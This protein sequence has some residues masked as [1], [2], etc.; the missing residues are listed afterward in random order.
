MD[1][2]LN[3]GGKTFKELEQEIYMLGCRMCVNLTKE[4]LKSKDN[5][6]FSTCDKEKYKSEGLRK[7]SIKTVY[8]AVEYKRRVYRTKDEEGRE[9]YVYL[10]DKELGMEKIGLISENL[11]EK[12][13]D[14]ATEAPYRKTA[15]EISSTTGISISAQGAWGL[16]QQIG[17]RIGKEE[18]QAVNQMKTG[19]TEGEKGVPVLLEEMDGI[20]IGQQGP[21]HEKMPKQEVKVAV[22]YEGWDKEKELAGRSTLVGKRVIAGIESSSVFHEKREADIQK[23]YDADEIIQRVVNGDGG[24][25]IGEPNDPDAII[26]LDQFHLYKEIKAKIADKEAQRAIKELLEERKIDEALSYIEIYADSVE[27]DDKT[28][29][30][31]ENARKLLKYM[32]NNKDGL[33]PWT[34][35]GINIPEAPEGIIYKNMGVQENQ[36]CTVISLRMKRGRMRWSGQG[37]NNMA[38]ALYRKENRE[39]HD[40][41]NRYSKDLIFYQEIIEAIAIL[42]A[43]KAPKK[44]GKGNPYIDLVN[45]HLPLLDAKQT[46]PRKAFKLWLN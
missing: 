38:K 1:I 37:G 16:M 31:S 32:T 8:G 19:H 24:S 29:N 11:A 17:E 30:R 35:R 43:A 36:N 34:E 42:S 10:L 15:D 40:T 6:I 3:E 26:Q 18:D 21:N 23:H 33:I 12:I 46:E 14:I 7:T 27:S 28:D 20:W 5:E 22:T 9:M 25:W 39:L 45:K 13:A 41:I 4:V 2:I 44:D